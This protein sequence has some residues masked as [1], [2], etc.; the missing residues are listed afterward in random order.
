VKF[1]G[2]K[3]YS[4]VHKTFIPILNLAWLKSYLERLALTIANGKQ[5]QFTPNAM[6]LKHNGLTN[7]K[8]HALNQQPS[9][10]KVQ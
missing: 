2:T 3:L 1:K 6:V 5:L 4:P 8:E 7:D 9:A 10:L